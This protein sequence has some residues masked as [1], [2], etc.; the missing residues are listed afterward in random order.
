MTSMAGDSLKARIHVI[1][2]GNGLVFR[3]RITLMLKFHNL[4]CRNPNTHVCVFKFSLSNLSI[5]L[6]EEV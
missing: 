6:L 4:M 1:V 5:D 2:E 3:I